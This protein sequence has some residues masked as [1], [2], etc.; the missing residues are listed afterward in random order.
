M[1]H[2]DCKEL[3]KGALVYFKKLNINNEHWSDLMKNEEIPLQLR[4]LLSGV[5]YIYS[6]E[7]NYK[8]THCC[9]NK[10]LMNV[11]P[12]GSNEL[13]SDIDTQIAIDINY[14]IKLKEL[15]NIID[16]IIKV[17]NDS[18]KLWKI[19]SI[20]KSLDIN[21]YPP[22]I[23]NISRKKINSHYILLGKDK[24]DKYQTVW[25]PQLK[26]KELYKKFFDAEM[27]K[28]DDYEK[29]YNYTNTYKYYEK[30]TKYTIKCLSDLILKQKYYKK[31]NPKH[32]EEIN[33]NIL[34]LTEYK[35]IGPEMYFT[36]S[37]ILFVVWFMQL[38]HR[39]PESLFRKISA[40]VVREQQ[41]LY[42]ITKKPKYKK[43]MLEAKRYL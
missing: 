9:I 26:N 34:C 41:L 29:K 6:D 38:N 10:N 8:I 35:H 36:Y 13:H 5:R 23:F 1:E 19:E 4:N 39:V 21:Y 42:N 32:D 15:T 3:V 22:T 7:V 33:N 40:I 14:K 17:L 43:R 16:F 31:N 25:M 2:F 18:K 30:Y 24:N 12:T 28:L 20:E 27:S 11:F 37:S